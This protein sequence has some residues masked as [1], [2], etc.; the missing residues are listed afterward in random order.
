MSL[1]RP[2]HQTYILAKDFIIDI[3]MQVTLMQLLQHNASPFLEM[4]S[5]RLT[6]VMNSSVLCNEKGVSSGSH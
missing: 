3:P 5:A 4:K 1:S 6:T 2:G